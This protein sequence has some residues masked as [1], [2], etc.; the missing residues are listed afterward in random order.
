[1]LVVVREAAPNERL[2]DF[3]HLA[4]IKKINEQIECS[5]KK[6]KGKERW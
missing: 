5:N 2:Q 1:V 6:L 4:A 3:Q